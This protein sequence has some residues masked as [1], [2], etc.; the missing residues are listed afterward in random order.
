MALKPGLCSVIHRFQTLSLTR[1]YAQ[2]PST[3]I[4]PL[5]EKRYIDKAIETGE[6]ETMKNLMIKCPTVSESSSIFHDVVVAKLTNYVMKSNGKKQLAREQLRKALYK[7]KKAQVA[8]YNKCTD[9]EEKKKI[10]LD[11]LRILKLAIANARPLMK[12]TSIRRGGSD[13]QV[14]CPTNDGDATTRSM[15][16]L[17]NACRKLKREKHFSDLFSTE[18]LQAAQNQGKVINQ[19]IELHKIC[20]ANRAYAHFRWG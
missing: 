16:N 4:K 15:K 10:I 17:V 12:L 2:W 11:P 3:S 13:Y 20:E 1:N 5:V 9:E 8:R 19:K 6:A 18:I 7:V 14:P